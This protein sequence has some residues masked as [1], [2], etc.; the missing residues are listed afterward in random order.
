MKNIFKS[1]TLAFT[2]LLILILFTGCDLESKDSEKP[3]VSKIIS[4]IEAEIPLD[5][6]NKS[7]NT[8]SLKR[9]FSLNPADYEE[10]ILF[11]PAS[12][13]DVK[14]L[15]IIK[16]KNSDQID[17]VETAIESRIDKQ[18]QSFSGYGPEQCA[19]LDDY[20]LKIKNDY[21]FYAV[22]EKSEDMKK[23]FVDSIK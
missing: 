4:N 22:G 20:V 15:M 3:S 9:F 10:V 8:K 14:E 12:S 13:M 18:L 19:L 5:F 7:D 1:I 17:L 2:L 11:T 23:I 16:L 21:I 6:V